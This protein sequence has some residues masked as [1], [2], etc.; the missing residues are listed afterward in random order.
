MEQAYTKDELLKAGKT[1]VNILIEKCNTTNNISGFLKEYIGQLTSSEGIYQKLQISMTKFAES[2]K[3]NQEEALRIMQ[4]SNE[5]SESLR[6]ICDEFRN[7]NETIKN[8]QQGRKELDIKVQKLNAQIQEISKS[9]QSIKE[10][11]ELTNLLSFNASI[12]AARAGVAGKG[13]RIIANEVK[14][15][16]GRTSGISS[17][18]ESKVREIE[19]EIKSIVTDNHSNDAIMDSLQ[20]TAVQ[21]SN[22]LMKIQSDNNE[23]TTFMNDILQQMNNNQ[24]DILKATKESEQENIREVKKIASR[25][26]ESTIQTGDQLSFLFELNQLFKWMEEHKELFA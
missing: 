20:N 13:F 16:S 22:R 19:K 6:N 7:L 23:N 24:D 10:V 15:L 18:I 2:S 25:A 5:N 8:A 26:A 12:E 4:T 14:T 17:E 21:S 1:L 9:I 11:S 3:K